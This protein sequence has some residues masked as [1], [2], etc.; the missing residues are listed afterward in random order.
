M[1]EEGWRMRC[2][3]AMHVRVCVCM[4][5]LGTYL[6]EHPL[7]LPFGLFFLPLARLLAPDAIVTRTSKKVSEKGHTATWRHKSCKKCKPAP[8]LTNSPPPTGRL[9]MRPRSIRRPQPLARWVVYSRLLPKKIVDELSFRTNLHF[10]EWSDGNGK[11]MF[12]LRLR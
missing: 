8:T 1:L 12:T 9:D 7:Y 3:C 5:Q 10:L 6:I 4:H 11:D 2:M